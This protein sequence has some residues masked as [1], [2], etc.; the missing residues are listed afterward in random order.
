M[1][2]PRA[3]V[4]PAWVRDL[5]LIQDGDS[6]PQTTRAQ[7]LAGARRAMAARPDL[8]A[9]ICAAPRG[10]DLNDLLMQ[11]RDVGADDDHG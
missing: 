8:R 10:R 9:R 5:I 4:P 2:D 3:F 7:L 1:S 6:D 11:A